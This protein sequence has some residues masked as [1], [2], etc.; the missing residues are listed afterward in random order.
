MR[1]AVAILFALFITV[2]ATAAP[3]D[4]TDRD[5]GVFHRIVVFLKHLLPHV[6]DDPTGAVPIP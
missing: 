6:A 5:P 3:N 4:S 1:K 2:S